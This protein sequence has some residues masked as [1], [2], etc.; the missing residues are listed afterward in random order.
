[1]RQIRNVTA[2]DFAQLQQV[3]PG[4]E[5]WRF[6]ERLAA[7]ARGQAEFLVVADGD[8]LLCFVYLKYN[9]KATHPDYPDLEDLYTRAD[10]R[11]Q[12]HATA[13]LAACERRVAQRGFTKLGL[14]AGPDPTDPGHRLYVKLGYQHDGQAMYVDGIYDGVEDWVIDMEKQ[15]AVLCIL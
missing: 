6:A 1:M 10:R 11:Q 8:E 15:I 7:Q 4:M 5:E 9:G 12:G 13:L 14:A 3:K 2:H